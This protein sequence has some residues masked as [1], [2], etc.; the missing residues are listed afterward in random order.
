[1]RNSTHGSLGHWCPIDRYP[2]SETHWSYVWQ[3]CSGMAVSSQISSRDLPLGCPDPLPTEPQAPCLDESPPPIDDVPSASF[4]LVSPTVSAATIDPSASSSAGLMKHVD[5]SYAKVAGTDRV[6]R[7]HRFAIA[8]RETKA[9]RTGPA[10]V[11][12]A[13]ELTAEE[14]AKLEQIDLEVT[15]GETKA[16]A[17]LDFLVVVDPKT[18][19]KIPTIASGR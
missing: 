8:P 18:G 6:V 11:R 14:A 13:E 10:E 17:G 4:A 2:F 9:G 16:V 5:A 7:V 12:L 15:A 19:E 3:D 1:M